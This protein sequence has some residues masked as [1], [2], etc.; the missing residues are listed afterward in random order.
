M[1]ENLLRLHQICQRAEQNIYYNIFVICNSKM[2]T[3]SYAITAECG[4]DFQIGLRGV[5]VI[6]HGA[7]NCNWEIENQIFETL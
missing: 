6:S 7:M 1:G 3:I 2:R 5:C 4:T